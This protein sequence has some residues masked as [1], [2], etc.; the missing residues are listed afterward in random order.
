[1]KLPIV[2][3]VEFYVSK[4]DKRQIFAEYV[5]PAF[6]KA[7]SDIRKFVSIDSP[8]FESYLRVFILPDSDDD[9][10]VGDILQHIKDHHRIYGNKDTVTPHVRTAGKLKGGVVEYALYNDMQQY[11]Q[12]TPGNYKIVNNPLHKFIQYE[13]NSEQILPQKTNRTLLT[14]IA[15]YVNASRDAVILFAIWLVQGVCEGNHHVMLILASAGCGKSTLSKII[16]RI[17]DPSILGVNKLVSKADNLITTLTNAYLVVFDNM[18]L[19]SLK[20]D[21]SDTLC[22][23]VTGGTYSKREAYS[24]NKLSVFHLHNSIVINGIDAIPSESDFSQ[25]CLCLQLKSFCNDNRRADSDIEAD[26]EQDLPEILHC[27]FDVV[28]KAMSIIHTIRPKRQPRML[29]SY[30]EML[31]IATAM[32]IKEEEFEKIFFENIE[33]LD[34]LRSNDDLIYA[35]RE[36][37]SKY[38]DGKRSFEGTAYDIHSKI[39][40]NYSGNR[41]SLPGSASHFTRRLKSE[42]AALLAAG[43]VV[44]VDDT[45]EDGTY[46]KIIKTKIKT[47]TCHKY[48]F[49]LV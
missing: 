14:I 26:F 3:D 47:C 33:T 32:E 49:L 25:R 42:Y 16:R 45:H 40:N 39:R 38:C 46:I 22:V 7:S 8:D 5:I 15:Q 34:K 30:I 43:F 9:L 31:A 4:D 24:N 21:E 1:M 13:T 41:G 29:E 10:C 35:I 11:V 20:K 44:N 18:Q 48:Q 19:R 12:I 27:I 23:A 28:S 2:S 37:F 17:L 36:Y 6:D